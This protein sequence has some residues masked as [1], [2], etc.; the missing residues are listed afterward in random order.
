M[1]IPPYRKGFDLLSGYRHKPIPAGSTMSLQELR[2]GGYVLTESQ[3]MT[4]I[5]FLE[6]I[7]GVPGFF[8]AMV[9][10]LRGLR[11]LVW[12]TFIHSHIPN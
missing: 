3:W 6:T 5:L 8:A 7:A 12:S 4:R 1:V 2:K 9:R 10:H 11:A